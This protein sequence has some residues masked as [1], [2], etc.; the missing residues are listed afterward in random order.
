MYK[1]NW[2]WGRGGGGERVNKRIYLFVIC[3][4]IIILRQTFEG[5]GFRSFLARDFMHRYKVQTISLDL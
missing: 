1:V 3:L 2:G 4:L 5:R